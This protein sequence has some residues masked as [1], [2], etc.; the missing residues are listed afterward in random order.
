MAQKE[1]PQNNLKNTSTENFL[2]LKKKQTKNSSLENFS[3]EYIARA[4]SSPKNRT[5]IGIRPRIP[6]QR[7]DILI[8]LRRVATVM[9]SSIEILI[10]FSQSR[11]KIYLGF[12]LVIFIPSILIAAS[13]IHIH[14]FQIL[15]ATIIASI[16]R[17]TIVASPLIRIFRFRRIIHF[18]SG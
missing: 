2:Y 12:F 17:P 3:I 15:S 4:R 18:G 9:I 5:L 1:K 8:D 14:I 7:Q 16:L 11:K 6:F 10:L 13:G